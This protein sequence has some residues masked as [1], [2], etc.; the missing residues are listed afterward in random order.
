[1]TTT[2][3]QIT[4]PDLGPGSRLGAEQRSALRSEIRQAAR[5][6]EAAVLIDVADDA[7]DHDPVTDAA[8]LSARAVTRDFHRLVTDVFSLDKPVVVQ[9]TGRVSGLGLGLALAC[10]LRFGTE[11]TTIAIGDLDRG[12]AL[13]GGVSWLLA[14]RAGAALV[15]HLSWTD[16]SLN[17]QEAVNAHLLSGLSVDGS[18]AQEAV[19]RL[20]AAPQPAVSALKRSL[21]SRLRAELEQHLDYDA[22]LATVALRAAR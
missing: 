4:V 21:N 5:G 8:S 10:D 9:L 19:K 2:T 20:V 3:Y 12:P 13:V 15:A 14:Q 11:A 1:M 22:W 16:A 7:W 17:A 6:D 18:A